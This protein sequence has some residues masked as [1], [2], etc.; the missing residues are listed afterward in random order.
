MPHNTPEELVETFSIRLYQAENALQDAADTIRSLAP[1]VVEGYALGIVRAQR[2]FTL[3]HQA[4]A[5]AG[6]ANIVLADLALYHAELLEI[7]QGDNELGE[8][9][10]VPPIGD[11][12]LA[13]RGGTGR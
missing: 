11:Q 3:K 1:L 10:D 2:A 4:L 8:N 5:I 6:S 7:A 9:I 12:E 13:A